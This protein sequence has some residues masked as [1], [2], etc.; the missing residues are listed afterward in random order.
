MAQVKILILS[1][2]KWKEASP[3]ADS[4]QLFGIGLGIT[5]STATWMT[6]G[7]PTTSKAQIQFTAGVGY[8]GTTNGMVWYE[9]TNQRLR[10]VKN[11]T[12][13]DFITSSNNQVL[14]GTPAAGVVVAAGASGDLS[15]QE[16]APMYVTDS[17]V[18]TAVN[19][20]TF[21]TTKLAS[22][23]PPNSKVMYQGQLY[24]NTT[25]NVYY[26]AISDNQ[27]YILSGDVVVDTT[28]KKWRQ[29]VSTTGVIT[30]VAV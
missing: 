15:T 21:A 17:D 1:G 28:G 9:T 18:I 26:Q 29:T 6:L 11:T 16:I 13:V 4:I 30:T 14:K 12:A 19:S 24:Y 3:T 25:L 27:V 23:T 8:T 5:A 2:G 7:A 10:M 22:I 20:A